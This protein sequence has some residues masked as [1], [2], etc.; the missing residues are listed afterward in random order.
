GNTFHLMLRPGMDVVR[1]HGGL[2][3]FMKWKGP[4]LT[5]S[6]GSQVFSLATLRKITEED[7][8]F[9]SPVTAD[10]V[11]RTPERSME[12]QR[13]L[14]SDIVMICD[15]CTPHPATEAEARASRALSLR[16]AA[17]SRAAI[18]RLESSRALF[19]IVQGGMYVTPREESI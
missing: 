10:P 9:R 3:G 6:G 7:L 12:V 4:I 19:G 17:R 13:A 18:D 15:E 16:W 5:D 8:S 11:M 14:A 2:H 1:A